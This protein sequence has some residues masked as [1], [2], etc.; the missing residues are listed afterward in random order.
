[1]YITSVQIQNANKVTLESA[2]SLAATQFGLIEKWTKLNAST[3]KEVLDDSVSSARARLGAK[4][5][6]G[7][8]A[9]QN[10]LVGP[11]ME[12]VVAYSKGVYAVTSEA[13]SELS[14]VA[15]KQVAD[16]NESVRSLLDQVAKNAP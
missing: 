6:Q 11:A 3:V 4:D 5:A 1:M 2:L 16:W 14:R 15:E 10:T 8:I 9:L 13:Q 12:K 7:Y